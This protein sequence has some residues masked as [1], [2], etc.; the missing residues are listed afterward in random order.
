MIH[1]LSPASSI[2]DFSLLEL[3]NNNL[4]E[5][6]NVS[7]RNGGSCGSVFVRLFT[8]RAVVIRITL[9]LF[10]LILCNY[11]NYVAESTIL[12]ILLSSMCS[13]IVNSLS[14]T[15]GHTLM[16]RQVPGCSFDAPPAK[17]SRCFLAPVTV[18]TADCIISA[19]QRGTAR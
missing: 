15:H 18:E 5:E 13:F 16:H 1:G 7:Y 3:N 4:D 8:R 14:H 6:E 2:S 9:H 17:W 19:R 10:S 11:R 12:G